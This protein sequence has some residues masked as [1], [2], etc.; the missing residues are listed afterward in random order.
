M[1]HRVSHWFL[2][3]P[4]LLRRPHLF[5]ATTAALLLRE[6]RPRSLSTLYTTNFKCQEHHELNNP[7]SVRVSCYLRKTYR[8]EDLQPTRAKINLKPTD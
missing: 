7:F 5:W 8:F 1:T 3:A 4:P 6:L 2:G